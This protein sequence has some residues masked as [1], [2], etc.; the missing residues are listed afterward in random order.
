[1]IKDLQYKKKA[2]ELMDK[3]TLL[4]IKRIALEASKIAKSDEVIS[5]DIVVALSECGLGNYIP[6][7][8]DSIDSKDDAITLK[9]NYSPESFTRKVYNY[10]KKIPKGKVKTY[11]EVAEALGQP[12]ASRAVGNALQ[13]NPNPK[14]VPCHRVVKSDGSLAGYRY[15]GTKVKR[16]LLEAEGIEFIHDKVKLDKS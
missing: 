11:K 12:E 5:G 3:V 15:G 14:E 8:N 6:V 9:K 7:F 1:M 4:I 13:K 10:V 2:L 16:A